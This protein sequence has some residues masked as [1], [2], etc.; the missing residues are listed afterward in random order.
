MPTAEYMRETLTRYIELLSKG[1]VEAIVAL[2]ADDGEIEDPV[3]MPA[4]KGTDELRAFYAGTAGALKAEIRGPICAAGSE[5]AV[6]LLAELTLPG[7]PARYIDVV[8]LAR[9]D[10]DGKIASLRAFWSPLDMRETREA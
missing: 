9:F 2:Y 1:D 8:D 3:G 7:A 10:D 4:K 6:T 5:C